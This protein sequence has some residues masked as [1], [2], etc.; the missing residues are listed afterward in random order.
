MSK[1]SILVRRDTRPGG[2]SAHHARFHACWAGPVAGYLR[3]G[4]G[5]GRCTVIIGKDTRVSGYM[6]E[7]ALEAGWWP[8]G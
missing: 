7:S 6:F 5:E 3:G 8:R 2:T 4:G 1:R